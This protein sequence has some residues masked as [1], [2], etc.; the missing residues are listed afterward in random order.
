[1]TFQCIIWP[2]DREI[3]Q[4]LPDRLLI[5]DGISN[6]VTFTTYSISFAVVTYTIFLVANVVMYAA[7]IRTLSGRHIST[8]TGDQHKGEVKEVRNQVDRLLIVLG[9]VFFIC[10]SPRRLLNISKYVSKL[11]FEIFSTKQRNILHDMSLVFI[12]LNPVI[13]P[14]LYVTLSKTYRDAFLEALNIKKQTL[15]KTRKH[16]N[17]RNHRT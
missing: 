1:M 16:Q 10:Q 9:I 7:T 11:V 5:C 14:Y 2:N 3:Y 4:S 17:N 13:N 8:A 6:S 12:N 15:F